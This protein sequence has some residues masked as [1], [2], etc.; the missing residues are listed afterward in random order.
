MKKI[1][2]LL[3]VLWGVIPSMLFAQRQLSFQ[4]GKFKI[5]QFT[6]LHWTSGSP[7]CAETER[8]IRTILK[9]EIRILPY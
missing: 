7:K 5:V 4:N 6:D 1:S 3:L 9:S 8:T 2:I